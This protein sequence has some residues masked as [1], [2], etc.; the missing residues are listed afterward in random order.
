MPSKPLRPCNKAGCARLTRERYCDDHKQLNNSYDMYRGTAAQRGYNARW[1]KARASYLSQHPICI[2]CGHVATVVDHII[3]HK[4]DMHL[5][6]TVSNWQSLCNTCHNR[7]TAT[8]DGGF[9]R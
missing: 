6:W 9:G 1:R 7:K 5:F 2:R 4:G 3:A 8:E